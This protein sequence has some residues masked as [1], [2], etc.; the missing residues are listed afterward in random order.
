MEPWA[1]VPTM[2]RECAQQT[3]PWSESLLRELRSPEA[4]LAPTEAAPGPNKVTLMTETLE[5]SSLDDRSYRVILLPNGLEALLAHDPDA[6]MASASLNVG[7]GSFSD[8]PD[9]PGVAHAL[10]HGLKNYWEIVVI[11]FQYLSLL[12]EAPAT[13]QA[14][15][16]EERKRMGDINFNFEKK[17][18]PE[19]FTREVSDCMQQPVPRSWLLSI[20][21]LRNFDPEAIRSCLDSLRPDNVLITVVSRNITDKWDRKE[22]WC[23]TEYSLAPISPD[24]IT[25]MRTAFSATARDRMAALRLPPSNGF[26]PAKFEVK[27]T[28]IAVPAVAPRIVRSDDLA[29]TWLLV[30]LYKYKRTCTTCDHVFKKDDSFWVPRDHVTVLF[31][32]PLPSAA[33]TAKARLFRDLVNDALAE[34]SYGAT[35]AGL[36]YKLLL[37]RRG[38]ELHVSGYHDKLPAL[39]EHIL[40]RMRDSDLEGRFAIV[41]EQLN[42]HYHNLLLEEPYRQLDGFRRWLTTDNYHVPELLAELPGIT[43]ETTTEFRR[44]LLSQ[45]HMEILVHGN[46]DEQDASTLTD[47]LQTIFKPRALE[48]PQRPTLRSIVFPPGS[49]YLFED[50]LQEPGNVDHAT[51]VCVYVGNWKDHRATLSI[52]LVAQPRSDAGRISELLKGLDLEDEA[53]TRAATEVLQAALSA[54]AHGDGAQDTERARASL[55]SLAIAEEG[56][57]AVLIEALLPKE[58]DGSSAQSV[59]NNGITPVFIKDVHGFKA[60]LQYT[61]ATEPFKQSGMNHGI[62]MDLSTIDFFP[63]QRGKMS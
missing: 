4:P 1:S 18:S 51:A 30:C 62:Q 42:R 44:K 12:R 6:D 60:G 47:A 35:Q 27:K 34:D 3:E 33:S 63:R 15:I 7:V 11:F 49:K 36:D 8:D 19:Q 22:R 58:H 24:K 52:H 17:S 5:V 39:L 40:I 32:D 57:V 50:V 38:L 43:A 61:P 54:E 46:L 31:R 55:L 29:R 16:F 45:M 25:K 56:K 14:R 9:M 59:P 2:L 26:I 20:N 23:G 41:K 28:P 53:A 48:K 10:K 13:A 21:K 37:D